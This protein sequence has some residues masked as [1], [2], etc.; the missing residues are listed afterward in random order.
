M[1]RTLRLESGLNNLLR[2]HLTI[3]TLSNHNRMV[4]NCVGDI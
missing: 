4:T 2:D 3:I 1:V